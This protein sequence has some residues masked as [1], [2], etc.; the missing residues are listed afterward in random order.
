MCMHENTIP[1]DVAISTH[2]LV[3]M[4]N[5]G[6]ALFLMGQMGKIKD[7][8]KREQVESIYFAYNLLNRFTKN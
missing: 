5:L 8:L 7:V 4:T 3:K 1:L 6:C 2:L